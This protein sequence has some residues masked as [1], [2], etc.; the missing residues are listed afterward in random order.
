[1]MKALTGTIVW[2]HA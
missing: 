1:V 2:I